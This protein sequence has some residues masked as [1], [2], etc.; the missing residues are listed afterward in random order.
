VSDYQLITNK[1][2]QMYKVQNK[3][4]REKA[5]K[6]IGRVLDVFDQKAMIAGSALLETMMKEF[7]ATSVPKNYYLA[8]YGYI[9][10]VT[11]YIIRSLAGDE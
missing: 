7:N 2:S 3:D 4:D 6:E 9:G 1:D 10:W 8:R 5:K 11:G